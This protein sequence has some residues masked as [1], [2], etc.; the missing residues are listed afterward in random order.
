M[1]PVRYLI[2]V[3]KHPVS[4]EVR[5]V[6]YTSKSLK[7][8]L[9]YHYYDL[10]KPSYSHKKHWL[11]SLYEKAIIE[12][13]DV[14]FDLDTVRAKEQFYI[15]MFP[16]LVNST[17]G[18]ESN[19]VLSEEVK[20]RISDKMKGKLVGDKNP[21]FGKKRPDLKKRNLSNNPMSDPEVRLKSGNRLREM[22]NTPE[23]RELHCKSQKTR[24]PVQKIDFSGNVLKVYPSLCKVIEDGFGKKEVAAVCKGKQ[25][26]HKGFLWSY[27]DEKAA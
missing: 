7:H 13:I 11:R 16:N 17:T 1:P 25:R 15:S 5:Y 10:N 27:L 4:K 23:Y 26:Q 2:Y 8:R 22:Y 9:S 19:K 14:C 24:T 3:L 6:G 18:G 12:Q 21:M 20:K